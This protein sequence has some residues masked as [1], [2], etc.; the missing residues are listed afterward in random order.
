MFLRQT[1]NHAVVQLG[2]KHF[3]FISSKIHAIYKILCSSSRGFHTGVRHRIEYRII[4]FMPYSGNYRQR[5]LGTSGSKQIRIK[6]GKIGSC[7]TAT[8]D[9]YGI[10]IILTI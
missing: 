9:D 1:G 4:S 5:K 8:D 7:S 3:Q 6:T 10:K 2:D